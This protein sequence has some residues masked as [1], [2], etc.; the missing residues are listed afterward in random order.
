[1]D[2]EKENTEAFQKIKVVEVSTPSETPYVES[3]GVNTK[4]LEEPDTSRSAQE[5][6]HLVNLIGKGY[7]KEQCFK[8]MKIYS[9]WTEAP[10]AYRDLT[11]SNALKE[12][13]KK[14]QAEQAPRMPKLNFL[15]VQ[16]ILKTPK[17][18]GFIIQGLIRPDTVNQLLSPPANFKSLLAMNLAVC[19]SNGLPFLGFKTK[20]TPVA[21][22][23][24]ENNRDLL[25]DRLQGTFTGLNLKKRKSPLFFL[26]K[27]GLLDEPGF[28]YNLAEFL[29]S[30]KIKLVVFDTLVRFN[31]G[32]ENS[33]RDMN[34][35]YQAFIELQRETN[36][37][38]LFLHHTNRAGE[39]RGSSD[40][41]GQVDTMFSVS[42]K[43]KTGQFVL[44]NPKN[45]EG[46]LNDISA[47]FI[48]D[49][50]KIFLQRLTEEEQQQAEEEGQEKFRFARAFVLKFAAEQCPTDLT[51]F[52]RA[53]LIVSLTAWNI[54]NPTQKISSRTIDEILRHLAKIHVLK[55]A[56]KAGQYYL[57][58]AQNLKIGQWIAPIL[59][60]NTQKPES[61][62]STKN[63]EVAQNGD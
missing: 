42:R 50:E 21:Y 27:E 62:Q 43:G 51:P 6:W 26:L 56:E 17:Q 5:Y 10:Q 55:K 58:H 3:L 49:E 18:K 35:I 7:T 8:K 30:Q 12:A 36:A 20:K 44:S 19:V 60:E 14:K 4:S 23:D 2:I 32:E 22:L 37:A 38:I 40:L 48:F 34:R 39:F 46:E 63:E 33:A 61:L 45:R 41:L 1:M 13:E 24:K 15:N 28:V 11:Y 9:K 53:E 57:L 29:K 31:S 16:E 47:Q 25:R 59:N 52:R 54:D